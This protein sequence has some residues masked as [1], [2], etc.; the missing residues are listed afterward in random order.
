MN[1]PLFFLEDA[2]AEG[3][4]AWEWYKDRSPKAAQRFQ[5]ALDKGME[6]IQE[7]PARWP[8]YLHGTQFYLIRRFPYLIVFREAS[9]TIEIIAVAH[10]HRK[11]GYWKRRLD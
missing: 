1:K 6:E 5:D 8:S 4:N 10:T 7:N 11:E 3:R 9:T 2:V